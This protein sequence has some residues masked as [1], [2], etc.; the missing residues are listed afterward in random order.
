MASG[1]PAPRSL[2]KVFPLTSRLYGEL[3]DT[4]L[5]QS[6]LSDASAK[7]AEVE[8]QLANG[9][10]PELAETSCDPLV[11]PPESTNEL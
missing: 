4:R 11:N 10:G 3:S 1:A 2:V 7:L 6:V 5:F 9:S 8:G